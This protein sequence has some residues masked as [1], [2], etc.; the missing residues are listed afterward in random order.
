MPQCPLSCGVS[1]A[2]IGRFWAESRRSHLA[3]PLLPLTDK[4]FTEASVGR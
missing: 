2:V 1:E 4:H 3:V